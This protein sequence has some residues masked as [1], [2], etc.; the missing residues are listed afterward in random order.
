MNLFMLCLIEECIGVFDWDCVCFDFLLL[1]CEVYGKL[2][3]YFDNVNIGQ[4]LVQVIG[5]VDEFYC[6]Y[7]VNV[8]CVVYVLG[9]EVIDVYEGVCNILVC[10]FNVC[11]SDL[12]LCSGIIFVINLVVYLW[13]L[14]WLKV[15][16]VILVLCMEYYVNIVLWQLVVQCIGVII[17]VVEIMFDG[18]LD[19]DVLCVVMIFEVKLLVVIYV[20]NVF[21]MVNLVCEICCEV[22]KCGIIIVVDGLQVVLY[23]KVDVVVIGC[24]F[25]VIIGYKMCGLIGIGVLWVCCEYL[26]VMLLFFGGGE[27]IKEVSFDG[28]VFNDVLYKFEVGI[29]NIVGFIGLGVVVDYLQQFGQDNVEV[30]EVELLVYFIEELCCVDGL[31]IIGQ[32]LEKVVVVLFL[33]DGVYVYD[34]VILFDLEGVVV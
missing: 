11:F 33:I 4:K 26:D 17:C 27:M 2:L 34:L 6:C 21:G 29:L 12:V 15:G 5:V 30:C 1:M 8:S 25:Y 9:S 19:L 22:C 31:C 13:V 16:D 23:C 3:V 28:I 24:D 20:F 32:V 7:N 18:V 14:S 10:F